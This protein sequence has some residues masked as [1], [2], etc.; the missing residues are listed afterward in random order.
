[1]RIDR[2]R[3]AVGFASSLLSLSVVDL[4]V[5]LLGWSLLRIELTVDATL[6]IVMGALLLTG[7]LFGLL[8]GFFVIWRIRRQYSWFRASFRADLW[9]LPDYPGAQEPDE[10][11]DA[12]PP[13]P[14]FLTMDGRLGLID[15]DGDEG[16][17]RAQPRFLRFGFVT[18]VSV[19]PSLVGVTILQVTTPLP[20][21]L[22]L[23][24]VNLPLAGIDALLTSIPRRART[25]ARAADAEE[26]RIA[27][28]HGVAPNV[29]ELIWT[30]APPSH[31]D[32]GAAGVGSEGS[33]S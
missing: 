12:G 32:S 1:M 24:F 13:E 9:R 31:Q 22:A 23:L 28:A 19:F 30:T 33:E 26:T 17:G 4:G 20:S 25:L 3:L 29:L 27:T 14:V 5:S 15:P 16:A 8:Y 6:R 21:W 11:A 10:P 2:K 7:I 18:V